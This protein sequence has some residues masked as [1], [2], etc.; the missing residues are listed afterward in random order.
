MRPSRGPSRRESRRLPVSEQ[1]WAVLDERLLHEGWVRVIE[2]TYRLPDGRTTTWELHAG[3]DSIG[4]LALTPDGDVVLV[5]QFRPGPDRHLVTM[6]GGIIEPAESP[7]QAARRELREETGYQPDRL[8]VV[9]RVVRGSST[10]RQYVALA[11]DCRLAGPQRLDEFED[12][13]VMVVPPAEVLRLLRTG[14]MGGS[15]L[16]WPALDAAGLL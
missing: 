3:S 14:A 2:R 7:E 11:Y 13:Q 10:E 6:P 12:C 9:T 15:Q 5:R 4:V 1:G 16:V 8:D